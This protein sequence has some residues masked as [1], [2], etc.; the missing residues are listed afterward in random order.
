MNSGR[1]THGTK[2]GHSPSSFAIEP[3]QQGVAP[4]TNYEIEVGCSDGRETRRV[5]RLFRWGV[6]SKSKPGQ[7]SKGQEFL[8]KLTQARKIKATPIALYEMYAS[9]LTTPALVLPQE[10]YTLQDFDIG[11]DEL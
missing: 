10:N 3:S 1:L 9:F 7:E 5:I 6:A 8:E 11:N 4:K 2:N